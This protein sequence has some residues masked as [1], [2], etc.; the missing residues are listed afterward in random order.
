M[1]R[2]RAE[3]GRVRQLAERADQRDPGDAAQDAVLHADPGAGGPG[4]GGV[5]LH[6]PQGQRPGH[7]P[8]PAHQ[9][10]PPRQL[11]RQARPLGLP[12]LLTITR[13]SI[14]PSAG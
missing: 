6:R 4:G 3:A 1:P 2:G 7:Q 8:Q 13:P 14:D 10:Q 5:P 9:P 11:L 12:V